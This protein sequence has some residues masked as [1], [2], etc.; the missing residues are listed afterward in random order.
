MNYLC[1]GCGRKPSELSEYVDAAEYDPEHYR[2][3]DDYVRREEG[4]LNQDNGH[5]ACT[6]CWINMGMPSSVNGWVAP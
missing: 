1:I 4:T 6:S 5:F 3:A 2:D